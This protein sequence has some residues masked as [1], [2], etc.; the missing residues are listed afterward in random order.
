MLDF[1]KH[2]EKKVEYIE[3]IYDLIF[4]YI[5]GRNNSLVQHISGGFIAPGTFL[6][7]F[8]CTLITI[9][10]WYMT[11]T[12]INR[13]GSND[14]SEYVG[15]FINMYLLYYMADSTRVHWQTHFY[16]YNIAWL[17]IVLNLLVQYYLKYRST[18]ATAPWEGASLRQH[19]RG[20]GIQA[21]II[22]IGIL[23]YAPTGLPLT[24]LAMIF[25]IFV[26]FLGRKRADLMAVDFSHLTERIMLY[27]VFTFGEMIIAISGYFGDDFSVSSVYFSLM[28]FL[29]VVGL[30]MSYGFLYDRLL[31]REMSISG[32]TYMLIHVFIIFSLSNL[33]TALEFMHEP[34]IAAVPKTIFLVVSF[35]MY[36]VFLFL[37]VPYTKGYGR[38]AHFLRPFLLTLVAFVILMIV[39]YQNARVNIAVS[40]LLTF[41]IW[42]FEYRYWRATEALEQ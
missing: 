2:E 30:F 15:L 1:L 8:I 22:V 19:M 33:T 31:D 39:F 5:I 4:V 16:R 3:L 32:N 17:L 35:V 23:L 6:T 10:I 21:A 12:F 18:Q 34:E 9:Q 29:I 20:L 7:Y 28:G 11:T 36:Y 37:T 38:T 26:S 25:G 42:Y 27:I 13:F 40:V 24:P 41:A 14:F